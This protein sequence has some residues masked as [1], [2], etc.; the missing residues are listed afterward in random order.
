MYIWRTEAVAEDGWA[1]YYVTR[2]PPDYVEIITDSTM[3]GSVY[4]QIIVDK[5]AKFKHRYD[6]GA[7]ICTARAI[8]AL[9][10]AGLN[11]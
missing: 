8:L 2:Q 5:H 6:D 9:E 1:E 11:V 3:D 10:E 7:E 4:N